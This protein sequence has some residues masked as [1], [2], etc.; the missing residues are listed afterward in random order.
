MDSSERMLQSG[1]NLKRADM[2]L[3]NADR[4]NCKK[5]VSAKVMYP[6]DFSSF[7]LNIRSLPVSNKFRRGSNAFSPILVDI[8]LQVKF[9][10]ERLVP[11]VRKRE[12]LSYAPHF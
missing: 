11:R 4:I 7:D 3:K 12:T 2:V 6:D 1:D 5:F 8:L 10:R 9:V